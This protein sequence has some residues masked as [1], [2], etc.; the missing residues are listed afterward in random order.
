[1]YREERQQKAKNVG[2]GLLP[3]IE[4]YYEDCKREYLHV[5]SDYKIN[6]DDWLP[7]FYYIYKTLSLPPKGLRYNGWQSE[8]MMICGMKYTLA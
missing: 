3:P 4:V 5:A 1:M 7:V 8:T 2:D 6:T